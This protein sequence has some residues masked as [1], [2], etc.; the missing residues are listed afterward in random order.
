M[1][2]TSV[3]KCSEKKMFQLIKLDGDRLLSKW[4]APMFNFM[5]NKTIILSIFFLR[6]DFRNLRIVLVLRLAI[7]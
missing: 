6:I 3:I 7:Y 4:Y 1:H 5:I 2:C